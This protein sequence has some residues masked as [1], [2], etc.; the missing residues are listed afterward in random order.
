MKRIA[1]TRPAPAPLH[2]RFEISFTFEVDREG[3]TA[4]EAEAH[5]REALRYFAGA[6]LFEVAHPKGDRDPH[7]RKANATCGSIKT[8]VTVTPVT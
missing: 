6:S 2:R 1:R 8:H 3:I 7:R 4:A 5:V